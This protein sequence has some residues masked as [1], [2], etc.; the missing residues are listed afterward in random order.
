M[1]EPAAAPR[2]NLK[3]ALTAAISSTSKDDGWSH[4]GEVGNY[5]IKSHAAFDA[6]DYGHAK[7]S[8]LVRAQSYVEVR[9]TRR[10][11]GRCGCV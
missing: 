8:E 5:L 3:K 2:P 9:E 11:P 7:L 1:S 4:L 6:R 10:S